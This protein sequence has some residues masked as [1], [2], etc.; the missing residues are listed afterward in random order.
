MNTAMLGN[1]FRIGGDKSIFDGLDIAKNTALCKKYMGKFPVISI[2]LKSVN[3]ADYATA[4]ALMC[5]TIGK[6]AM[7]FYDLL[8][9]DQ[10]TDEDKKVY[11]QL[12]NVDSTGQ[13]VYAMSDTTLMGSLNTLSVLL[14]KHYE[15]FLYNINR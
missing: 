14:E 8:A 9:S 13:S 12:I 15:S 11:R 4:R 7:K 10:L 2:S 3:G 1:F 5:L 6:E